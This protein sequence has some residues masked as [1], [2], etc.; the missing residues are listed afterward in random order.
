MIL[1]EIFPSPGTQHQ[2]TDHTS[3]LQKLY[4]R[5][6][7]FRF[8]YVIS[9]KVLEEDSD[10]A[11][12]E[13]DRVILKFIRSQSD[14]IITTGLTAISED[15]KS[16]LFAPM[17][18]LTKNDNPIEIPALNK[19][20][21]R[22]VFVTQRLETSYPNSEAIAIGKVQYPL[23]NFCLSFCKLNGF[24]TNALESGITVATEFSKAGLLAEIDLT[25]TGVEN[26]KHA[27]EAA[28]AFIAKLKPNGIRLEQLLKYEQ[29]WFFRFVCL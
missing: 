29:C 16:S 10:L 3:A 25:V 15:L 8:N 14:L 5:V 26:Q 6:P 9:P 4:P 20:S 18:I 27:E 19:E 1:E 13:L 17:L 21:T 24:E 28:S 2:V 11:T 12:S 23:T 22:K 7:G